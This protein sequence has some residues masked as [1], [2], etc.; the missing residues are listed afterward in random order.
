MCSIKWDVFSQMPEDWKKITKVKN[1]KPSAAT[2]RNMKLV[3]DKTKLS[4]SKNLKKDS[5][6][7]Q[8]TDMFKRVES[9]KFQS[10]S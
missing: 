3:G 4:S 7:T 8:I 10:S 9:T 1:L 6:Q 2:E 5:N